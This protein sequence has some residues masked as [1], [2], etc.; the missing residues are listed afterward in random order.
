[1]RIFGATPSSRVIS[2]LRP[3]ASPRM[4]SQKKQR[5]ISMFMGAI[6]P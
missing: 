1:M 5:L 2:L 6:L 4:S 3:P